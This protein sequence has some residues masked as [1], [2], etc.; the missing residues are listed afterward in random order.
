ME[1]FMHLCKHR[2]QQNNKNKTSVIFSKQEI[3]IWNKI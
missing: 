2:K 1:C 3:T